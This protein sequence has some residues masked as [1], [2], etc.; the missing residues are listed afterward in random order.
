MGSFL[1]IIIENLYVCFRQ[2]K[3]ENI[4]NINNEI[5]NNNFYD[6][7]NNIFYENDNNSRYKIII[8]KERIINII[9]NYKKNKNLFTPQN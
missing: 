2:F 4:K 5:T 3:N 6:Y 1:S 9:D 8:N 7:S